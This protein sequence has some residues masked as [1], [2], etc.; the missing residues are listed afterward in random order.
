VARLVARHEI[1]GE[2]RSTR[3]VVLVAACTAVLLMLA[4]A[5]RAT[6][7]GENGR[8]GFYAN[9]DDHPATEIYAVR[10]AGTGVQKLTQLRTASHEDWSPDGTK[11]VFELDDQ[12]AY[13]C[14]NAIWIMNSDGS[15]ALSLTGRGRGC[16]REPSFTPDGRR[17]VFSRQVCDHGCQTALWSM[18]LQGENRHLIVRTP[19]FDAI[20]PNVSPDGS[21]ITFVV[22]PR[23]Y[24]D[25]LGGELCVVNMNGSHL[26]RIVPI[27]RDVGIK[28]DWAPDGSR[29]VFTEYLDYNQEGALSGPHTP[30]VATVKPDGSD[31][32]ELTHRSGSNVEAIAGSYS[33][34]G[35]W[36]VFRFDNYDRFRL[37]KMRPDGTGKT[38]IVQQRLKQRGMD[39]GPRPA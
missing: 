4:P 30:N 21:K 22:K 34:D 37:M 10:S 15:D 38:L 6:S 33:P 18:N 11:I 8:I 24:R 12:S 1:G 3:F 28:H 36:I 35:R 32:V 5:A 9:R 2:M 20:D 27:R 23:R 19:G 31:L 16:E 29:I 25:L 13:A 17:I 26:A 7:P 39:W 14:G